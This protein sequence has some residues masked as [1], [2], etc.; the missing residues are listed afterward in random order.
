MRSPRVLTSNARYRPGRVAR[1]IRT[2]HSPRDRER[3][4][5]ERLDRAHVVPD[6][7]YRGTSH[8]KTHPTRTLNVGLCLGSKGGPRGVGVFLWARYPFTASG[9]LDLGFWVLELREENS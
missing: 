9:I 5:V 3:A 1:S 2:L 4:P 7:P 6:L 8:K